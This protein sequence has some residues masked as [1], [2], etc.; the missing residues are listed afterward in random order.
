LL[1]SRAHSSAKLIGFDVLAIC[2]Q[3]NLTAYQ[4]EDKCV[5]FRQKYAFWGQKRYKQPTHLSPA[6][7]CG[8]SLLRNIQV[9]CCPIA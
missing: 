3:D 2:G 1:E 4:R 7:C 8:L 9:D 6:L 5:T